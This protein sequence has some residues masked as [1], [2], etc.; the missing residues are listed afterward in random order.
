MRDA[1][2]VGLAAPQIGEPLQLAV[3]EDQV[4][5]GG[6]RRARR[7]R[8]TSS[9]IPCCASAA[10]LRRWS[11]LRGLPQHEGFRPSCRGRGSLG[12]RPHHHGQP[13]TI[14]ASGWYARILQ[15]ESIT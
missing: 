12:Q 13:I 10:S 5:R 8:S 3:I 7:C 4:A 2:G 14:D 6:G 1:P 11:I 15:H 9:S